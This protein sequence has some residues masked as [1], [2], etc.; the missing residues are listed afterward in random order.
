[1]ITNTDFTVTLKK[2]I[3]KSLD[4]LNKCNYEGFDHFD[5]LS[6]KL[7]GISGNHFYKRLFLQTLSRVPL[8]IRP[9]VGIKKHVSA[10]VI[11]DL[12]STYVNIYDLDKKVYHTR[13]RNLFK[14]LL[15]LCSKKSIYCSW[16]LPFDFVSRNGFMSKDTPNVITTYYAVNALLDLYEISKD[17]NIIK[18]A[19]SAALFL[20]N[21]VGYKTC[22]TGLYF[23]YYPGKIEPIHNSSVLVAALLSRINLFINSNEISR[24]AEQAISYTCSCQN[25]DGSWYYGENRNLKWID[26]FHTGY[27]LEAIYNYQ[28]YTGNTRFNLHVSNGLKFF[29]NNLIYDGFLPKY[30]SN[31]K[32]PIDSQTIAQ[33]ILTYYIFKNEIDKSDEKINDLFFWTLNNFYSDKGYFYFRIYPLYKIKI[34]YLRWSTSTI[35][36][37]LSKLI[38]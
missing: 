8:N 35:L 5:G 27:V 11:S 29:L 6:S 23:G 37:S 32:Y 22:A 1:M 31:R 12:I 16:G 28:K 7:S 4:Y 26:N 2:V 24:L 3:F 21:E 9:I 17:E 18:K 33:T 19:E 38:K 25:T 13:L 20:I 36:V 15:K 34:P 30:Y 14:I 10:K